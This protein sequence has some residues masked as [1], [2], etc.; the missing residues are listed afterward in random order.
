[1]PVDQLSDADLVV[2]ARSGD[3]DAFCVLV[4]RYRAMALSVALRLSG[5]RETAED[6]VQE[7]TL[8]AFV[9]LGR[10]RDPGCFR[11]WF[12]GTVLNVT[13]A[14][15]RR[16]AGRPFSLDEWDEVRLIA[17]PVDLAAQ[18]ELRWIVTD[19]LRSV[20]EANRTV[21]MLLYYDGLSLREIAER[22]GV[23]V[24]AVKSRLHRGRTQLGRLLAAEYPELTRV[25]ARGERTHVMTELRI[26]SIV[27]F[28]TR[29]LAV[30]ADEPGQRV[31]PAWLTPMEGLPLVGPA[32]A[33]P[34]PPGSTRLPSPELAA[35]VLTAAGGAVASMRI[36][37]L[38]DGLLF[39]TLIISG[40][41]GDNEVQTGLGDALG[42]ARQQQCPILA[43]E[44]VLARHG[45][46]VPSGEPVEDLL[47]RQAGLP[48]QARGEGTSRTAYPR[49]LQFGDGLEHWSLRGSF[50]RDMSGGNWQD[51]ACGTEP[52][53]P[54]GATASGYLK[55]QVPDPPGFADLRQ[56]ILADEYRGRRV[57]LSANVRT[58][59]V[60]KR[61]GLYLRVI[62]PAR[63]RPPEVR[64][65]L[66][67]QGSSDWT[68]H[69]VEMDVPD[70]SVFVL[71]GLSLTGPGQIW[72][73]N[74]Q[75][76]PA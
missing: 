66:S 28:P 76:E 11:S 4:G 49:N 26:I 5:Q 45:V 38:D 1:M 24:A 64:E 25:A 18:R 36:G 6:L 14:W 44:D 71:F 7:A 13:R 56:G 15:R 23:S 48:L 63:S 74:V 2:L 21:L 40:P 16:Q 43:S 3:A 54:N 51:Y 32:K 70:N 41:T 22:L 55:A 58:A 31:L 75:V 37:E 12:Y 69:H 57:R 34:A 67:L 17:D 39:G 10:L 42:L 19:A 73:A 35:K 46:A 50:L 9:S 53:G 52:G 29:I 61:A 8:A 27:S 72:A 47:I 33:G 60:T 20:P 30:L 68:R 62:D 65:Q 59:D